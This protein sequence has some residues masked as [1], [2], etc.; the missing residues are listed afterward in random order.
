MTQEGKLRLINGTCL[1]NFIGSFPGHSEFKD[2]IWEWPGN[3]AVNFPY[4]NSDQCPTSLPVTHSN[5]GGWALKRL[6]DH[7]CVHCPSLQCDIELP[8]LCTIME[9]YNIGSD[10]T[11]QRTYRGSL[12]GLYNDRVS[13]S[14]DRITSI[15]GDSL[16]YIG[17]FW[18]V[19]DVRCLIDIHFQRYNCQKF[20]FH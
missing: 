8:T 3:E 16:D 10:F 2:K 5:I 19:P 7:H 14:L 20:I 17:H 9:W 13:S 11:L 15:P 1:I 4:V 18:L 6:C 12:L